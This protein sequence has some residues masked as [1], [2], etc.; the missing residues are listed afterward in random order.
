M[1]QQPA[2]AL[3]VGGQGVELTAPL[4]VIALKL[5]QPTFQNAP[6]IPQAGKFTLQAGEFRTHRI[7][8]LLGQLHPFIGAQL[9]TA[10]R[11]PLAFKQ[12]KMA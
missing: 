12:L 8:C 4:G 3:A 11:F 6:A 9:S 1:F 10:S 7:E 5:S 2:P